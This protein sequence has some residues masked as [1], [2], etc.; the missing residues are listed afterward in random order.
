MTHWDGIENRPERAR[1]S[2]RVPN[3][4]TRGVLSYSIFAVSFAV[5][6]TWRFVTDPGFVVSQPIHALVLA[7]VGVGV[8]LVGLRY[9]RRPVVDEDEL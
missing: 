8:V 9:L 4:W 2:L 6:L 3:G 7:A 5:A 1:A